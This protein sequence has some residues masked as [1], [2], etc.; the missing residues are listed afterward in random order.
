MINKFTTIKKIEFLWTKTICAVEFAPCRLSCSVIFY[1][2]VITATNSPYWIIV[3]LTDSNPYIL[4]NIWFYMFLR[5]MLK[6]HW[7]RV[8]SFIL[9]IAKS[10]YSYM[11]SNSARRGYRLDKRIAHHYR[12]NCGHLQILIVISTSIKIYRRATSLVKLFVYKLQ[13]R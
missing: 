11:A 5:Q 8:E 10:I 2:I 1:I 3:H 7:F 13:T 4:A 9:H 12:Y 6:M